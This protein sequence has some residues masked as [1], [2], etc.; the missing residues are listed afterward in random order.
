[1]LPPRNV[2]IFHAGALG[3]FVLSWPLALALGRLY[4][5]S[6]I[7]YVT[8]A[9]KGALAERVLRVEAVDGEVGGWHALYSD[10]ASALPERATKLLS[11]AHSI[12]SFVSKAE[13]AW[14]RNV[15]RLATHATV[16]TLTA[17]PQA[18][19]GIHASAHLLREIAPLP[20]VHGAMAQMLNSIQDRGAGGWRGGEFVVIHPGAGAREKCW[21][22]ERFVELI[23]QIRARGRNVRVLL[24]EVEAERYSPTEIDFITRAAGSV[25][26]LD[27]P[28][29]LFEELTTADAFIGNDSGPGH[30][31]GIIGVPTISIFRTTEP[32]VWKPLGP[33]VTALSGDVTPKDI[34][35]VLHSFPSFPSPAGRG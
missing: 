35:T 13:D 22:L 28:L 31:A 24:G 9:S 4:P 5:Q 15:A 8:H 23:S 18:A 27:T 3:D 20:A 26:R 25:M 34:L 19:E 29:Q 17:K 33:R 21:P 30:L 7:I 16:T 1:M 11:G 12:F 2:L 10:D 32:E 6:R 14:T